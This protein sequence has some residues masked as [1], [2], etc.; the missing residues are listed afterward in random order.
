MTRLAEVVSDTT[1]Q[2]LV[3][4]LSI[5]P[6]VD[7]ATLRSR[8]YG[9]VK[10]PICKLAASRSRLAGYSTGSGMRLSGS[11]KRSTAGAESTESIKLTGP[12]L[13]SLLTLKS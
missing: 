11:R 8:K 12:R 9:C 10:R 6:N 13:S 3:S 2:R 7:A 4:I 1:K 5:S